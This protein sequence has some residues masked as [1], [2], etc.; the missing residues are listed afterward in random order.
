MKTYLLLAS[1]VVAILSVPAA[2]QAEAPHVKLSTG[3]DYSTGS[4]GATADTKTFYVPVTAK[5][6]KDNLSASVTVPYISIEGPGAVIGGGDGAIQRA[7]SGAVT[8]E[9]G[10]GDVVAGV[11]YTVDVTDSTSVDLTGK[12]KLPTADDKKGLGTGETDY[13]LRGD[14]M[15]TFGDFYAT[16]GAGHK[17]V[18]SS[19]TLDLRDIW[20]YTAGVGYNVNS[21]IS[22][23]TAYDFRQAAGTG[24]DPSEVSLFASYKLTNSVAV[25][26]Y[27]ATGFSDGS[28][29]QNFG[30]MLSHKM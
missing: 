5:V 17:F 16:A 23:G 8:T 4:Y 20:M 30:L 21:D 15:Q 7:G 1:A 13:T 25:Q 10:L 18:G 28:P 9:S 12:V 11:T 14:L 26:A 22:V 19:A 29:E 2:A 6:S 27:G 3:V 24:E